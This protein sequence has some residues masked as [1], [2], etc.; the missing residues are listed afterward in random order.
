MKFRGFL[1]AALVMLLAAVPAFGR[2]TRAQ[3][4]PGSR[5][6]ITVS[7]SSNAVASAA[8]TNG[9]KIAVAPVS[10][11]AV[12][13]DGWYYDKDR[14]VAYIRTYGRLPGNYITKNQARQLGWQGGPLEPY[15]PGKA[16][17]GDHFGNYERQ[18]PN[19][20]WRECDIDTK[21][22]P[23]GAKRII[24]SEDKRFYYTSDHYQT[25]ERIP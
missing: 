8:S 23:R 1:S 16:I 5:P 9:L 3:Y 19:G 6:A 20:R 12:A 14:V 15:A 25:F 22:R 4:V 7:V 11:N 2:G 24:F 13:K 17:G 21:G 10:A 18:L